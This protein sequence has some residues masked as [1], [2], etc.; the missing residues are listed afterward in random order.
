MKVAKIEFAGL[1]N[2]YRLTNGSIEVVVTTD[3]GPRVLAYN[4]VGAENILG[5]HLENAAR[6]EFGEWRI[7]GGHR[8]WHAPEAKPRSYVP[9]SSHITFELSDSGILLTQPVE[10]PTGIQKEMG[11]TLGSGSRVTLTHKLTNRGIWPV[12]LAPW[13]LTVVNG[14]GTTIFPNEP[15]K[16]HSEELL[17]ARSLTVWHYT[18]LSDSRWRLGSRYT[19]LSTDE[20]LAHPQK[21]G[22]MNKQGWAAYLREGDLF[23]KRFPFIEGARYAD[24]GCNFETFTAGNFMEVESLGPLVTLQPGESTT[25]VEEWSLFAGVDPG[26][27]EE[28]LH[29]AIFPFIGG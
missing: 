9:D 13:A 4:L 6:T 11:V 28:E 3:A 7:L 19:R 27:T 15:Y 24:S 16:S 29:S 18:D 12:E 10:E 5:L 25:H 26:A 21:I 17:P 23:V 2:C 8:L 22:V 20:K 1:P 14:G